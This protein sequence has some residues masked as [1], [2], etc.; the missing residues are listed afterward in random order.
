MMVHK[1]A[2]KQPLVV[3]QAFALALVLELP[4]VEHSTKKIGKHLG[5]E[6]QMAAVKQ[7]PSSEDRL[8]DMVL[9]VEQAFQLVHKVQV[10][11]MVLLVPSFLEL[12]SIPLVLQVPLALEHLVLP[13]L[14]P[15]TYRHYKIH[16]IHLLHHTALRRL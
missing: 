2:Y 11:H 10:V 5:K 7:W 13:L 6:M 14:V 15:M 16:H 9:V 12:Q 3:E 8:V 4:M 1:K